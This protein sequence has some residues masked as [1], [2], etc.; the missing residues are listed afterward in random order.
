M[1][2]YKKIQ[3]KTFVKYKKNKKQMKQYKI[4]TLYKNKFNLNNYHKI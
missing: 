3:N 4:V 2:K 1:K